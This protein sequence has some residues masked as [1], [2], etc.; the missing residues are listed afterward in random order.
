MTLSHAV[1]E[2]G[3]DAVVPGDDSNEDPTPPLPAD[4][5]QR[6]ERDAPLA[7]DGTAAQA[8]ARREEP[9]IANEADI[10]SDGA[11]PLGE[12][13]ISQLTPVVQHSSNASA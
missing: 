9:E 7:P 8:A 5:G 11:D 12:R 1:P 10:P 2:E 13:M 4:P 6:R 3:E